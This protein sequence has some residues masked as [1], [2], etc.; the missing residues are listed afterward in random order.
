[1]TSTVLY[2]LVHLVI[3][4]KKGL[5]KK[6]KLYN[7][8]KN[9][10]IFTPF[11]MQDISYYKKTG[12]LDN[13]STASGLNTALEDIKKNTKLGSKYF[14]IPFFEREST[15]D[16]NHACLLV[17]HNTPND[18][19]DCT[20]LD[21]KSNTSFLARLIRWFRW[22][23]GYRYT[24]SDCIL[25]TSLQN[26]LGKNITFSRYYY[27]HQQTVG[28]NLSSFFTLRTLKHVIDTAKP[29]LKLNNNLSLKALSTSIP[30]PTG[31]LTAR[32]F[33]T[34]Q[35]SKE[36]EQLISDYKNTISLQQTPS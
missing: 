23:I 22:C 9:I 21:S 31:W 10:G 36:Y 4:K 26:K 19:Y 18:K 16:N 2:N 25:K 35:D 15:Q 24:N 13:A 28:K 17:I 7:K 29:A 11:N 12:L 27:G 8:A 14:F 1:M 3:S 33:L 6:V 20:V 34:P 32:N 30:K 5:Q